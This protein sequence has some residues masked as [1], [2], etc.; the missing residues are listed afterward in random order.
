MPADISPS[1]IAMT[2]LTVIASRGFSKSVIIS[3]HS[4]SG[5]ML[6][7][8]SR[9][10]SDAVSDTTMIMHISKRLLKSRSI[11]L[12]KQYMYIT[13]TH[14][15]TASSIAMPRYIIMSIESSASS[16]RF[17]SILICGRV[18]ASPATTMFWPFLNTTGSTAS[19]RLA[20]VV[21]SSIIWLGSRYGSAA[22]RAMEASVA[23]KSY[24]RV[25]VSSS[26][27]SVVVSLPCCMPVAYDTRSARAVLTRRSFSL[28]AS[29]S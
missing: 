7:L 13:I 6:T 26:E 29:I 28:S 10:T 8:I 20:A 3:A 27:L 15:S 21:A 18:T 11:A 16:P 4:P 5:I 24:M 22:L 23:S 14:S 12:S 9:T 17:C 1:S 25:S 2:V 19:R